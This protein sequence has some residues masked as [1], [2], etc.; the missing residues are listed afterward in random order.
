MKADYFS[1]KTYSKEISII[2][3]G[4]TPETRSISREKANF[5]PDLGAP[6]RERERE[7]QRPPE[8]HF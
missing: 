6:K 5:S 1:W 3:P 7:R 4:K 8:L 2:S